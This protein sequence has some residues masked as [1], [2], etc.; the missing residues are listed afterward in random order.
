VCRASIVNQDRGRA[1]RVRP[2]LLQCGKDMPRVLAL[3]DVFDECDVRVARK[4]QHESL[5][6]SREDV[7]DAVL[8]SI[9]DRSGFLSEIAPTLTVPVRRSR[10]SSAMLGLWAIGAQEMVP[11]ASMTRWPGCDLS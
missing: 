9:D 7:I 1:K 5:V 10:I 8:G 11:S 2:D 4:Y 3:L 6:G